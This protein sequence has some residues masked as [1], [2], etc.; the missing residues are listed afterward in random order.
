MN[1]S[2][3]WNVAGLFLAGTLATLINTNDALIAN[4]GLATGAMNAL[5][6]VAYLGAG[7]I[8]LYN[9]GQIYAK[10]KNND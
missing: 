9:G 10:K 7:V 5:K 4:L 2:I 6:L 1:K 3:T 8:A